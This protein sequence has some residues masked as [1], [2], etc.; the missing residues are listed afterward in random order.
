MPPLRVLEAWSSLVNRPRVEQAPHGSAL[1][2][3]GDDGR[4]Y[5]LK[6]VPGFDLADPRRRLAEQHQILSYL[7]ERGL[8]VAC[9]LVTD[10]GQIYAEVDDAIYALTPMLPAEN[11]DVTGNSR[12]FREIGRTIARLH[13]A[14]YDC[15][16]DIASWHIQLAEQTFDRS[17]DGLRELLPPPDFA[18]VAGRVEPLRSEMVAAF[19]GLP[20][21]R[22]HGD[23]HGGNILLADG[24]VSGLVDLE[25]LPIGPR[26]YDLAYNLSLGLNWMVRRPEPEPD[27]LGVLTFGGRHLLDGYQSVNSLSDREID[28]V[29]PIMLAVQLNLMNLVMRDPSVDQK[30]LTSTLWVADHYHVLR[31]VVRP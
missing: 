5:V 8:P 26:I 2:V 7:A 22:I 10:D 20:E 29:A 27:P 9:P 13:L 18:A 30:W 24:A 25:H 16:F 19:D 23:C 3:H 17:W 14:L 11:I 6:R 28:A 4:G 31:D 1:M 12:L 21:Q 15:P